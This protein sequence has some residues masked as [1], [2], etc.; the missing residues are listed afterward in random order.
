MKA[1]LEI[2]SERFYNISG[3]N[4]LP[5]DWALVRLAKDYT[6]KNR[7]FIEDA[8]QQY[9]SLLSNERTD[10]TALLLEFIKSTYGNGILGNAAL[11]SL[12]AFAYWLNQRKPSNKA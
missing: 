3:D 11:S 6:G 2:I 12:M 5:L 8:A 9:L 4:R 10:Y 1:P 7:N